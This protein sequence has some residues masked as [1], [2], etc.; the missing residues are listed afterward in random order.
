MDYLYIFSMGL[1]ESLTDEN[2][3]VYDIFYVASSV[4]GILLAECRKRIVST[5][6]NLMIINKAD[7]FKVRVFFLY[8]PTDWYHLTAGVCRAVSA[9][10]D[11]TCK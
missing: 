4:N 10:E 3:V 9:T 8:L 1:Q 6:L 7:R 2:S 5:I 11:R